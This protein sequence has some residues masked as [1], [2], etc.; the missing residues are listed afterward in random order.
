MAR[1][2]KVVEYSADWP[3]QYEQE[4]VL[5]RGAL[6]H[7]IVRSHHIGSTSVPGLAAKPIIDILLEV[8]SVDTLDTL[9][10]AMRD[11]GYQPKGEFGIPG[12]RYFPKGSDE[13]THH[14]HAFAVGDPLIEPHLAFRNYLRTHPAAVAEYAAV[15]KAAAAAH[16]TDPEGYVAF[17]HGFV[18][19]M[20]G[21]AVHWTR[22]SGLKGQIA[23][24]EELP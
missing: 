9:S 17:K 24:Q 12:R 18:E 11:L 16:E 7:E 21:E 6:G 4:F 10:E 8:R 19:R 22:K 15:K 2:M 14:V 3:R 23:N 13:R 20:V 1:R 5:L